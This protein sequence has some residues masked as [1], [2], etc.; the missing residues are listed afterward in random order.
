MGWKVFCI[1]EKPVN[2][3]DLSKNGE[4]LF[5]LAYKPVISG[6]L[7]INDEVCNVSILDFENQYIGVHKVTFINDD[8]VE[9]TND[10]DFICPYCGYIDRDAFELDDEGEKKCGRCNSKIRYHREV[11]VKYV[12]EPIERAEIIKAE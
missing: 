4:M 7:E 9:E 6:N 3:V 12:V 2:Y 10:E 5:E 11:Y 1:D 8:E